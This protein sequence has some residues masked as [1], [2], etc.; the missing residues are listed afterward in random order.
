MTQD[1]PVSPT[2]QVR[3][4]YEQAERRTGETLEAM[5][6]TDGFADVLA[7]VVGNAMALTK[8]SGTVLDDVVRRTRLA[9]RSDVTGLARQLARTEDKLE[10]VLQHIESLQDQVSQLRA[11]VAAQGAARAS[12]AGPGAPG[13]DA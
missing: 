3:Q 12:E 6:A 7:M 9:G 8:V 13:Q 11:E 1:G 4:A 2:D 5:V 10:L